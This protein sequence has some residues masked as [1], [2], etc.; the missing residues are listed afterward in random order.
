MRLAIFCALHWECGPILKPLRQVSR[1]RIGGRTAWTARVPAG[2]VVVVQTG[3]GLRRA[4]EAARA[5]AAS[6]DF[7]LFL[8]AGCGGALEEALRP[9]DLV[10]ADVIVAAG[11]RF[12]TD[13]EFNVMAARICDRFELPRR[14][15]PIL[16]SPTVLTNAAAR[17]VAVQSS[18]AIA[19]EMEAA[20]IAG[21]A[22]EHGIAIAE[23]RAILDSAD[24][25][26]HES[27]DFMDPGTGRL[28]PLDVLRAVA[29]Q[30]STMS[31]LW[32]LRKMMTSAERNLE[33]FFA[34]YLGST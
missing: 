23:L 25:E 17:R 3:V 29:R 34:G 13:P 30:P 20:A 9:G 16:T 27:G 10:V 28:R 5:V 1:L 21:V 14:E 6:G 15:G 24:V 18:G 19:V 11:S 22:R 12:D 31:K 7:D 33:R 26:L 4:E 32:E 8:S 2:D